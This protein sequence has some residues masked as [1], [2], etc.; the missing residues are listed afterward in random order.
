MFVEKISTTGFGNT[1]HL[2]K[3][4]KE[5]QKAEMGDHKKHERMS[6]MDMTVA[7]W[8]REE[9]ADCEKWWAGTHVCKCS[10]PAKAGNAAIKRTCVLYLLYSLYSSNFLKCMLVVKPSCQLKN[11]V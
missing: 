9:A 6:E 10:A 5:T 8:R 7:G 3:K 2:K 11:E 1:S 4:K